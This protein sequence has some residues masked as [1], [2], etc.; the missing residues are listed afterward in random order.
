MND[1][2]SKDIIEQ[3]AL[4]TTQRFQILWNLHCIKS[5]SKSILKRMERTAT[6]TGTRSKKP[7]GHTFQQSGVFKLK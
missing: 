6:A 7:I 2:F 4:D 1:Y 5:L 3:C